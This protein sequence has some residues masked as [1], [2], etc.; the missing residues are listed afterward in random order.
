ME[1]CSQS[2]VNMGQQ[3][4]K[5]ECYADQQ[6]RALDKVCPKYRFQSACVRINNCDNA[7]D[8]DQY[9]DADSHKVGQHH[10]WQVHDNGHTADLVNDKHNSSQNTQ[11]LAVKAQ[12][13]IVISCANHSSQEPAY[14]FPAKDKKEIGLSNVAKIETEVTHQGTVPSPLKY[15]FPFISFFAK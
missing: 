12:L 8:N 10:T 6:Y 5:S 15:S 4:N 13:Q 7:H 2:S 14:E 1:N 11:S 3:K 9:I